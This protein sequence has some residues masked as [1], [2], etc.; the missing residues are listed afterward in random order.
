MPKE[1]SA[2]AIIYRKESVDTAQGKK[3]KDRKSVV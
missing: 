3:Y 2:G 1:K